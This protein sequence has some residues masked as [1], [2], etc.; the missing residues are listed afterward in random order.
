MHSVRMKLQVEGIARCMQLGNRILHRIANGVADVLRLPYER[1][2][3]S[4][5]FHV[6][7][8]VG[9][10]EPVKVSAA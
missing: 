2:R 9:L 3:K 5:P 4:V 8:R 10:S 7:F 1:L 6:G